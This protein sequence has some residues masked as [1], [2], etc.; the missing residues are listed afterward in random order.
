MASTKKMDS[1]KWSCRVYIG[2]EDGKRKYKRFTADT[3]KEAERL[4]NSYL[5]EHPATQEQSKMTVREAMGAY[6]KAKSNVLS[7]STI[8]GYKKV[9]RLYLQSI[10]DVRLCDLTTEQIQLAVNTDAERLSQKT[11]RNSY[12]FLTAA[13]ALYG[14]K[15]KDITLPQKK[16]TKITIPTDEEMKLLC[17]A[18]EKYNITAEVH[19]AAYMG[20]RRSEISPIDIH[21]DIDLENKTISISKALVRSDSG[22]Y[23]SKDTKTTSSERML[24]IPDIVLPHIKKV[25]ESGKGFHHPNYIEK[26]FVLMRND[27]GL[28]HIKFHSLRHYF[29]SSLL[30]LGVPDF[31]SMKLMGHSSDQM[32]KNVY[33]HIKKDYLENVVEKMNNHFTKKSI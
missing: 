25:V 29:A 22:E 16:K 2:L 20:L 8:D 33:Q 28:K 31:Y 1:G 23:V 11:V 14:F 4:A 19:L 13:M 30:T 5:V 32:L 18:A 3:K 21:E 10:M 26:N 7:P 12:G 27:L 9:P 6:I 24:A 15:E 17:E